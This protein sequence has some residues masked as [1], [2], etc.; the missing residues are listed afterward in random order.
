MKNS[1]L[2]RDGEDDDVTGQ[3]AAWFLRL[4]NAQDAEMPDPELHAAFAEWM[5]AHESHAEAY[6]QVTATW[7]GVAA[8]IAAPEIMV[9][10]HEALGRVRHNVRRRWA[11]RQ[12]PWAAAVA[13]VVIGAAIALFFLQPWLDRQTYETAVG[14]T[15]IITLADNSKVALDGQSKVVVT[16]RPEGRSIQ[17]MK[18]HAQFNVAKDPARPF[19]VTAG[20]Q[21]IVALGTSFD[22]EMIENRVLVTLFEGRVSVSEADAGKSARLTRPLKNAVR[23]LTPGQQLV[24]KDDG[25]SELTPDV[26]VD[27]VM[28]WRLGKLVFKNEPL[29]SAVV[30]INRHSRIPLRIGDQRIANIGVGGVFDAGDATAFV[31]ALEHYFPLRAVTQADGAIELLPVN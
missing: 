28:A 22:V 20:N 23:E 21:A 1:F 12:Q 8:N 13:A 16:Y 14:E 10:R 24:V 6:R 18:G 31:D 2:S 15:R 17:L 29:S 19:R 25:A 4:R 5:T 3:A 11:M 26:N 27:S 30:R 9:M 7:G